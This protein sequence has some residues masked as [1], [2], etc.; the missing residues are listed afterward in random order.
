MEPLKINP[1][2]I[3]KIAD[4]LKKDPEKSI[5]NYLYK[6]YRIQ[7]SKYKASGAERVQQL[8]KRRRSQGLCIVCGTKVTKKNPLTGKLYRLCEV[9]RALIDQKNKEKKAKKGK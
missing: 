4:E 2:Q 6:G 3:D 1:A 7:I 5:G 9:H 8:Y